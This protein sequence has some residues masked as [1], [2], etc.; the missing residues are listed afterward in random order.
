MGK[1]P[2][3]MSESRA[4]RRA[5][6]RPLPASAPVASPLTT[7]LLGYRPSLDG[8]RAIAVLAVMSWHYVLPGVKGGFLGVDI[9]FVLSGFLITRLLVEEWELT[10]GIHL[11]RFYMRRALRLFP[12]LFLLLL[13]MLPFVPRTWT[14]YSLLYVTNW[15]ILAGK[16]GSCAIMQLWSLSVEEQFYLLWPPLLLGLLALRT[17][18]RVIGVVVALLAAVSAGYKIVAWHSIDSWSRFYFGSDARADELLIGCGLALFLSW[19]PVAQRS[20]FRRA[21]QVATIPALLWLGY[22]IVASAV[23]WRLLYQQ[24]G[25]TL[26]ALA[27]AIVI[28]QCLIAPVPGVRTFLAWRPMVVI[29]RMSYGVYL[30]HAPVAWLTDARH[31]DWVP[32]MSRPVQFIVRVVLTFAIAGASYRFLEQPL[33]RLKRRF[34]TAERE[35]SR[36]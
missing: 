27:T 4:S 15:G 36:Q 23:Y 10:G 20:W 7:P 19:S 34:S 30:W 25:L 31:Y 21:V 14:V 9:F 8:L 3:S 22:L 13:L 6:G 2:H 18:R 35:P 1:G 29:G 16:L 5:P 32:I 26:A 24:A 11:G 28:T 17:P 33:L 12:A